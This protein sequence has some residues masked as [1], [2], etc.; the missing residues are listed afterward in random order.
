MLCSSEV[1]VTHLTPTILLGPYTLRERIPYTRF[2]TQPLTDSSVRLSNSSF[3]QSAAGAA[4]RP[5]RKSFGSRAIG[6]QALK[7]LKALTPFFPPS[8][9]LFIA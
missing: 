7:V 4:L 1:L 9:E 8:A 2:Y 6:I 3:S 5:D